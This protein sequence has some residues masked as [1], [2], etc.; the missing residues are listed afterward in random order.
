MNNFFYILHPKITLALFL[1]Y[2]FIHKPTVFFLSPHIKHPLFTA[3][4]QKKTFKIKHDII[5]L[6]FFYKNPLHHLFISKNRSKCLINRKLPRP[7]P[8][9]PGSWD[10]RNFARPQFCNWL[11]LTGRTTP[12]LSTSSLSTATFWNSECLKIFSH[13]KSLFLFFF[14]SSRSPV[15][16]SIIEL[17]LKMST[18]IL[19]T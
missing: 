16:S 5:F 10:C 7:N 3:A 17:Q 2:T 8:C 19:Y 15:A 13:M 9:C 4:G 12:N 14:Q 11:K 6:H 1:H 18:Y